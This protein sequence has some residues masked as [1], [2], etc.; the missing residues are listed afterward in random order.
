MKIGK[1][2]VKHTYKIPQLICDILSLGFTVMIVSLTVGF[3]EEY[4]ELMDTLGAEHVANIAASANPTVEWQQ[5][6]SL[7][8]PALAAAILA[9]YIVLILKSHKF[10][11]YSVTK[12][13]AQKCYD[14]YAFFVSICKLPALIIVVDYTMILHDKLRLAPLYDFSWF[15]ATSLL[16]LIILAI[17]IRFGMHRIQKITEKPAAAAN[18]AVR[19]RAVAKDTEKSDNKEEI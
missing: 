11:K 7:I 15:S 10:S 1:Y 16:Y 3:I 2:P 9:A 4:N 8:C 13:T 6:L 17:I 5:W 19:V 12:L 18:D 14:T